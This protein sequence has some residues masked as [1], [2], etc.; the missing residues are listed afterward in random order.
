[1]NLLGWDRT[2]MARRADNFADRAT[3]SGEFVCPVERLAK[4]IL[5][6]Q[7]ATAINQC[8]SAE[9]IH[10]D[11]GYGPD[12][13]EPPDLG[14][15]LPWGGI[16]L[17]SGSAHRPGLPAQFSQNGVWAFRIDTVPASC[18]HGK[19]RATA[20]ADDVESLTRDDQDAGSG[21]GS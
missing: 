10:L 20:S 5:L 21:R 17:F 2:P 6:S 4:G 1:M 9:T 19:A 16:R 7:H 15:S 12:R 14:R 13:A 8:H 11:G 3:P 18:P